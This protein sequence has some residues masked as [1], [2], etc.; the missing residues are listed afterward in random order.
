MRSFIIAVTFIIVNCGQLKS[1]DNPDT[2]R[3]EIQEF[4]FNLP[5]N[6]SHDSLVLL[7]ADKQNLKGAKT[8]TDNSRTTT[9]GQITKDK[10]LNS[11]ADYN[12]FIVSV[13]GDKSLSTDTLRFEWDITY[14]PNELKLAAENRDAFKE[15]FKHL[16]SDISEKTIG[17]FHGEIAE[18]TLFKFNKIELEI[19]LM[20]LKRSRMYRVQ[21]R[22][23]E[24]RG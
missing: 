16:F 18:L 5:T 12:E 2:I 20:K 4:F 3:R 15:M 10:N 24:I 13:W 14:G 22:Y 23:T 9:A 7:L 6:I 11:N 17:G 21:I 19:H 1:Q 8:K